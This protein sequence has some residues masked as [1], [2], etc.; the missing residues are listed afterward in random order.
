MNALKLEII[1]YWS[2]GA[3]KHSAL[4]GMN[5]ALTR[6]LCANNSAQRVKLASTVVRIQIDTL[7]T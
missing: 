3:S 7:I 6:N 1:K 2:P 5:N 4:P